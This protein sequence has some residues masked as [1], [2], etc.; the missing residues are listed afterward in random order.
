MGSTATVRTISEATGEHESTVRRTLSRAATLWIWKKGA[1]GNERHFLTANMPDKYRI[2]LAAKNFSPVIEPAVGECAGIGTEAAAKIMAEKAAEQ[3]RKQIAMETGIAEFERLPEKRKKEAQARLSLLQICDSFVAAARYP[4]KRHARRS[5]TGDQAFVEAYNAGLIDVPEQ[6][7]SIIGGKTSYSTL[8]RIADAYYAGGIAA[9]AFNYHN[10]KRGCTDLTD[11]QQDEVLK[12]MCRNPETSGKNIQRGLQGRFGADVPSVSV[13]NR[14]RTRWISDNSELWLF[15]TNPDAWKDK[16]MFAFGSASE[17]VERLNQLWEADSTPADVMLV[18]GRHSIIGMIDVYSRRMQLFVSKTSKASSIVALI[19]HCLIDWGV[20]ESI[21]TDNGKDY[22]SSHLERVLH[23]LSIDHRLCVPFHGW[24]KPHVERA[25]KTFLHGLVELMPNY[26]GHNVTERKA[27]EARRSFADRVMDKDSEPVA[28]NM[29]AA[30]LQKFCNEWANLIYHNDAHGGLDGKTPLDMVRGWRQPVRRISDLRALDMLLL[31]APDN[32]GIRTIS[33]KGIRVD[34]R[35]YQSQEFA[36]HVGEAVYVLLDPADLG[37][38]YVYTVNERD[39]RA[40]LCPA[41][42]PEWAGIDMAGFASKAK[43]HQ[44]KIMR[45]AKR[46][47]TQLSKSAGEQEA[48]QEYIEMRRGQV[49]NIIEFP[50]PSSEHSTQALAEGGKAVQ[51]VDALRGL[52][53]G[54]ETLHVDLDAEA[55]SLVQTPKKEE[56]IVVLR[57]DADEYIELR[58]RLKNERR[59]LTA[60]EYQWLT[61]FYGESKSGKS[62]KALEGDLRVKIGVAQEGMGQ[63]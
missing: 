42:D 15:Y 62:Y 13:I 32:N 17:Y 24:E 28:I 21:K 44:D 46:E 1:G 9:L 14:F 41:I 5:K 19:R 26:I 49:A 59:K 23:G 8:R 29:S 27:I 52:D 36:G 48:Y 63:A 39:E 38:I 37:T 12:L 40:F 43:K 3:E 55:L 6:I 7:K 47:L 20:P 54:D 16:R 34:N 22:V 45:E 18:D 31:P 53:N 60:E 11:Q 4:V 58:T 25:F 30:E 10:P 33:K 51:A 2:A 56:K 61:W 57:T 35:Q 50:A